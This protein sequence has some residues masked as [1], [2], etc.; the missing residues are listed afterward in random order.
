M[1]ARN[2]RWLL[3]VLAVAFLVAA[4]FADN[5]LWAAVGFF[6]CGSCW[7]WLARRKAHELDGPQ[8]R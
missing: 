4:F 8:G 1:N 2:I 3:L 5:K 6:C 7:Y